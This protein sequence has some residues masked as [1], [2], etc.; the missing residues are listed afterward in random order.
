MLFGLKYVGATYK[1][2]MAIIFHDIHHKILEDY[3]DDI[4]EKSITRK[5]HLEVLAQI[6]D[7]LE[8]YLE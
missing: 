6:F 5:A 4:L 8:K 2:A 1:R 3:V 7:R